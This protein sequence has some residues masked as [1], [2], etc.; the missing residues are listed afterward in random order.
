MQCLY[1]GDQPLGP[2]TGRQPSQSCFLHCQGPTFSVPD[3]VTNGPNCKGHRSPDSCHV[4]TRLA[5]AFCKV[6]LPHPS[7]AFL[8][9]PHLVQCHSPQNRF[10]RYPEAPL[11]HGLRATLTTGLQT[12]PP[13]EAGLILS[14]LPRTVFLAWHSLLRSNH[15]G[16]TWL[17]QQCCSGPCHT[18][19]PCCG[20][21]GK[22]YLRAQPQGKLCTSRALGAFLILWT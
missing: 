3:P 9:A 14:S 4:L 19:S 2:K 13:R 5:L 8:V 12:F 16:T 21:M 6:S 10:H 20:V 11:P 1:K 7:I 15:T 18:E 17:V 22:M